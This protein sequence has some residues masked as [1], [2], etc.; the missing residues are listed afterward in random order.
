MDKKNK[1][2]IIKRN[3]IASLVGFICMYV[4]ICVAPLY[5]IFDDMQV[6][7]VNLTMTEINKNYL[8]IVSF[9]LFLAFIIGF[10]ISKAVFNIFLRKKENKIKEN[11]SDISSNDMEDKNK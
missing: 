10:Y 1:K 11:G 2:I 7:D 3:M 8:C 9:L 6:K 5:Q 4:V